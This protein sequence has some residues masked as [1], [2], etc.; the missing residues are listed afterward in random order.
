VGLLATAAA[1]W[2]GVMVGRA[3]LEAEEGAAD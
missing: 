3:P 1:T 2:S